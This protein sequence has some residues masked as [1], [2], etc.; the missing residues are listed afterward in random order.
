MRALMVTLFVLGASATAYAQDAEAEAVPEAEA[1]PVPAVPDPPPAR[2]AEELGAPATP[3]ASRIDAARRLANLSID[4]AAIDRLRGAAEGQR[5]LSTSLYVG[6]IA[7]TFASVSLFVVSAL[8][9]ACV[10]EADL[11][12]YDA[13]EYLV[14]GLASGAIGAVLL[15]GAGFAD[16]RAGYLEGQ[17]RERELDLEERRERL[18]RRVGLALGPTSIHLRVTF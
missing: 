9:G 12:C 16:R 8:Q 18:E 15:S 6:G 5:I 7:L 1:E 13:S 11:G 4:E 2:A 3:E 14:G 17:V 10:A